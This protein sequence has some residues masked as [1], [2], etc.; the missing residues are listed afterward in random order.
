MALSLLKTRDIWY[1]TCFQSTV[2]SSL[3]CEAC[4]ILLALRIR[5]IIKPA[6]DGAVV[7]GTDVE[8]GFEGL[9]NPFLGWLCDFDPIMASVT[10]SA[11]LDLLLCCALYFFP[12]LL[13]PLIEVWV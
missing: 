10:S 7:C 13:D 8:L 3:S 12:M 9:M 4:V 6:D 2:D 5:V 1:V 11:N